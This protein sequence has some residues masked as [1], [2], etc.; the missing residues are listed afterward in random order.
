MSFDGEPGGG[1]IATINIA[2]TLLPIADAGADRSDVQ[3]FTP[4]PPPDPPIATTVTLDGSGSLTALGAPCAGTCSYAWSFVGKPAGSGA[5]LTGDTTV[6]PSFTLDVVGTYSVQLV[7]T[8]GGVAS[9]ADVVNIHTNHR[10]VAVASADLTAVEVGEPVQLTGSASYDAD[11]DLFGYS[12]SVTGGTLDDSTV[13]NP[14]WNFAAAGTFTAT[15]T[16][17]ES[18]G[19]LLASVPPATVQVTVSPA[20]NDPPVANPDFYTVSKNSTNNVFAVLDNDTDPDGDLNPSTV[21]IVTPPTQGGTVS[22]NAAGQILYSPK[23]GWRGTD[24]FTYTVRDNLGAISNV[25]SVVV[26]VVN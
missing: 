14:T 17:T 23:R 9:A 8:D 15:L 1:L 20:V 12:W 24:Y 16:V 13:A 25:A 3:M 22:V 21:A 11:G 19:D 2:P 7:V 4:V 5:T 18:A 26:N 10:P 6:A